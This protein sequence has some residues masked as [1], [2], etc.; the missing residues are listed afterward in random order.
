MVWFLEAQKIINTLF[1][2]GIFDKKLQLFECR[3][4]SFSWDWPE[5]FQCLNLRSESFFWSYFGWRSRHVVIALS[6]LWAG[7]LFQLLSFLEPTLTYEFSNFLSRRKFW[8]FWEIE[9]NFQN[10]LII[11]AFLSVNFTNKS[12]LF[13]SKRWYKLHSIQI[14]ETKI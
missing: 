11:K 2:L 12:L 9:A 7:A 5:G 6:F 13:N 8:V 3:S 10:N 1:K 4:Q 14:L